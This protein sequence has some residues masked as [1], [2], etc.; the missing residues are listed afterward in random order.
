[1][2]CRTV[3]GAA[4][5]GRW[6]PPEGSWPRGL[7]RGS[8]QQ[9]TLLPRCRIGHLP[10]FEPQ[11]VHALGTRI[12]PRNAAFPPQ[13]TLGAASGALLLRRSPRARAHQ[14]TPRPHWRGF[15]AGP[16]RTG[17]AGHVIQYGLGGKGVGVHPNGVLDL[18]EWRIGPLAVVGVTAGEVG[19]V[20]GRKFGTPLLPGPAPARTAGLAREDLESAP[21]RP[22]WCRVPLRPPPPAATAA[23]A[24]LLGLAEAASPRCG[25]RPRGVRRDP[26]PGCGVPRLALDRD[27]ASA[28]NRLTSPTSAVHA[29]GSDGGTPARR[30][31]GDRAVHR[32]G[33]EA[34]P[35]RA[36]RARA[37]CSCRCSGAVN[38]DDHRRP[39]AARWGAVRGV[40]GPRW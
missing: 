26:G 27:P 16:P 4:R 8:S 30:R 24:V 17:E 13:G 39:S 28:S 36:A 29:A 31:Q 23:A 34:G 32:T 40:I 14:P 25:P 10:R 2:L 11:V 12:D 38:G 35:R 20:G 18:Q 1:M 21:G 22:M 15:L 5:R 7:V 19:L 6:D 3:S 37:R 33:I 9:G